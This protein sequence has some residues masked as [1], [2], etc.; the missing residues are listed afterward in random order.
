[1][2]HSLPASSG[3]WRG[4]AFLDTQTRTD[5]N[6]QAVSPWAKHRHPC[7]TYGNKPIQKVDLESSQRHMLSETGSEERAQRRAGST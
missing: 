7:R 6:V 2:T 1:M 3:N 5:A 4:T